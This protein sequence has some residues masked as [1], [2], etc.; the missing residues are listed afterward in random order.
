M[1]GPYDFVYPLPSASPLLDI[2]QW[3]PYL[4]AA[5]DAE[6]DRPEVW[7][8]QVWSLA[9]GFI[10]D[11]RAWLL[12]YPPP[13]EALMA[14]PIG[15]IVPFAGNYAPAGWLL[16]DG[17]EVSRTLYFELYGVL[18]TVYGAGDG[19]D[20]FNLPNLVKR[21][22]GGSGGDWA[23]GQEIGEE[24]HTLV[25][26]E[27]PRGV[28]FMDVAPTTPSGTRY[29]TTSGTNAVRYTIAV[30]EGHNNVQPTLAVNY[31]IYAIRP[32]F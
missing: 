11:L 26:N 31:I 6:L 7:D 5:V 13:S 19:V 28:T 14:I 15:S 18:G 30:T 29:V 9:Q 12:D 24:T 8:E 20:T 4:L 25:S 27:L 3:I 10:E 16:C 22:P 21:V 2:R 32:Q 23:L 17:A 1:P